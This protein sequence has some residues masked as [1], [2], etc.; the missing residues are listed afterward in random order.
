MRAA[1]TPRTRCIVLGVAGQ[2]DRRDSTAGVVEA[3][4]ALGLPI[5]SDEIYDGLVFDGA[6]RQL[7]AALHA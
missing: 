4:C 1:I 2:S 5:L 3:L 7:A 6:Q